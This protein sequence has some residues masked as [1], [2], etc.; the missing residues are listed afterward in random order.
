MPPLENCH[1]CSELI[2]SL[3]SKTTYG[4]TSC[5]RVLENATKKD[6]AIPT[7]F[8]HKR[9]TQRPAS[10]HRKRKVNN[11]EVALHVI[12]RKSRTTEYFL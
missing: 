4:R 12:Y 8:A 10:E 11:E 2:L 9:T 5:L 7:L 1:I 6:D 3:V